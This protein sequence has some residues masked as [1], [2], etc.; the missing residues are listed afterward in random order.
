LRV[1]VKAKQK[2]LPFA[3]P[4]AGRAELKQVRQ[5]LREILGILGGRRS[6]G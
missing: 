2:P 5:G 6:A 3:L 1:E 4:T